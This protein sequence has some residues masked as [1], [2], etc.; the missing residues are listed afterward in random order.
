MVSRRDAR[1]GGQDG[2]QKRSGWYSEE[3]QRVEVRMV[4]KRDARDGSQ[5]DAQKRCK[6]WRLGWYS[7]EN[8]QSC[9]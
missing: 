3:M 1:D 9:T 8:Y 2:T 5:N 6:G 4:P 7:E